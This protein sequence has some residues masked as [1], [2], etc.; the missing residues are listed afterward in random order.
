MVP[1]AEQS[2]E[3]QP[4]KRTKPA[5]D[6]PTATKPRKRTKPAEPAADQP[7]TSK[8]RKRTKPA[9]PAADQPETSKPRKRTKPAEPAADQPETSKPRKRTRPAAEEPTPPPAD[10][11]PDDEHPDDQ[12]RDDAEWEPTDAQASRLR[13]ALANL[14]DASL[15]RGLATMREESR[16]EVAQ[17]L[18]L[19]KATMH[20]GDALAP[21]ARRKIL[22]ATR[23]RQLAVAFALSEQ[24]NEATIAALGDRSDD[25]THDDIVE[26]LPGVID[27]QGLPLVTLLLAAYAASDA[28]S[29]AVCEALLDGDERFAL[30]DPPEIDDAEEPATGIVTFTRDADDPAQ[31]EKRA[32]RKEAK[33]AKRA[34]VAAR[35]EAEATAQAARKTA[36]HRAKQK[37][38]PHS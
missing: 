29:Q 37:S 5:A 36:Q 10:G 7:E 11:A 22:T 21:L 32:Q 9:A 19:S 8:P 35:R 18:N 3:S 38:R 14:D 1:T 31:V 27:K 28:K 13:A 15:R 6:Q 25:P 2:E 20:L 23:G 30:P 34:A 26:V 33:A 16:S 17:H 24:T 4:R 12:H